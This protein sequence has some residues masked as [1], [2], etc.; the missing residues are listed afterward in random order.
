MNPGFFADILIKLLE[1]RRKNLVCSS[2]ELYLRK[3]QQSIYLENILQNKRLLVNT[4][5]EDNLNGK[6][7]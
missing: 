4:K 1:K 7:K 2:I 6:W 3:I 5:K